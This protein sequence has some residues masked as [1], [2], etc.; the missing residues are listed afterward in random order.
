[1]IDRASA[2]HT[3]NFF[4]T[5]LHIYMISMLLVVQYM[6]RG[7]N[8]SIA[9]GIKYSIYMAFSL[10]TCSVHFRNHRYMY[11]QRI[12]FIYGFIL[13]WLHIYMISMLLV[14]QYMHRISGPL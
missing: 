1:M 5:W 10:Y 4:D 8:G 12:F 14:V 13:T 11:I 9:I 3:K 2:R 7:A 6:H